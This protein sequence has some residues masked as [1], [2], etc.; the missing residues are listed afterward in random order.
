[1]KR[2]D[3]AP[4][5]HFAEGMILYGNIELGATAAQGFILEPPDLQSASAALRNE[6]QDKLRIFL[7][8]LGPNQRAQLQWTCNSDYRKELIR[9]HQQTGQATDG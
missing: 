4:N 6:F 2:H 1:M 3:K 8:T 7:A 5:G 9:Y